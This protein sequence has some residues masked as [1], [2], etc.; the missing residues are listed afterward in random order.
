MKSSRA[1]K[2]LPLILAAIA[3][4]FLVTSCAT[5]GGTYSSN[6]DNNGWPLKGATLLMQH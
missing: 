3:L 6:T 1:I 4:A 5:T 2:F